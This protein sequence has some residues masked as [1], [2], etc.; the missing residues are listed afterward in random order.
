MVCDRIVVG[1]ID[2]SLL[3]KLKLDAELT[4]IT[5]IVKVP[6]AEEV[7]KQQTLLRGETPAAGGNLISL[8][9]RSREEGAVE[10]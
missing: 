1:I 10:D 4:L 3:E 5:A 9:G 2:S 8:W 6:Q 7:K